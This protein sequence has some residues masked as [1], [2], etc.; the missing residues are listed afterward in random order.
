[1]LPA[2]QSAEEQHPR[3]NAPGRQLLTFGEWKCLYSSVITL[4]FSLTM[5]HWVFYLLLDAVQGLIGTV[6]LLPPLLQA[7]LLTTFSSWLQLFQWQGECFLCSTPLQMQSP[8]PSH[9]TLPHLISR[10]AWELKVSPRILPDDGWWTK[11][12]W[13]ANSNSQ[14]HGLFS[15]PDR[16]PEFL[17]SNFYL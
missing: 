13:L 16:L 7:S 3:G 1:M 2:A 10:T 6:S 17:F 12:A 8:A 5:W 11:K 9:L 4:I 15:S 14:M